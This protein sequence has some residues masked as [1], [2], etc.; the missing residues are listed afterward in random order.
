MGFAM[1]LYLLSPNAMGGGVW[2]PVGEPIP[3]GGGIG[4]IFRFGGKP[5]DMRLSAYVNV[6][7]PDSA[8]DWFTEF[9][10]KLMFP[11]K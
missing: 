5:F 2:L 4:K 10:I 9:Q 6:E 8:A 3:L 1:L 11:K 7:A